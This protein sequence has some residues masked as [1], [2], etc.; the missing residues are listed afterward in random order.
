MEEFLNQAEK[1]LADRDADPV[2]RA[3]PP[4]RFIELALE[5]VDRA[6]RYDRPLSVAMIQIDSLAE[7]RKSDGA[8]VAEAVFNAVLATAVQAMRG[9]DRPG[10]LGHAELG[11]LL[12]ETSLSHA[13]DVAG[14]LRQRVNDLSFETPAGPR[15][16]TL[17]IGVASLS[18]RMRDPKTFLM[19]A[20]FELRRAQ[21]RGRN[22]VCVAAPD[23][24]RM[25]V[26]RSGQ[27][28]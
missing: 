16:A 6:G 10:R 2:A 21:S 26:P 28:H 17:S 5:E 3:L 27:I 13:G 12:P 4:D 19:A 25:T 24:V 7:I 20:Y 22:Q 23:R 14:R 8:P 1:A 18:P 15:S 11:V 9:P